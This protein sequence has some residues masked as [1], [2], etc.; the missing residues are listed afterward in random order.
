ML[1]SRM[2]VEPQREG[3]QVI[4]MMRVSSLMRKSPVM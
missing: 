2:L 4:E 3:V 1:V